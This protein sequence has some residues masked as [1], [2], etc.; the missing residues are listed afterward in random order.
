M[1]FVSRVLCEVSLFLSPS[2][3]LSPPVP[4]SVRLSLPLSLQ[5]FGLDWVRVHPEEDDDEG[6]ALLN[7]VQFGLFFT[8]KMKNLLSEGHALNYRNF[9]YFFLS[10]ICFYIFFR[11]SIYVLYLCFYI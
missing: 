11:E 4:V 9:V 10:Y 2:V 1:V 5:E 7:L 3:S 8:R 6:R